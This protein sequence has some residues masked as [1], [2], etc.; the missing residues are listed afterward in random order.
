MKI[1]AGRII[2]I[3][4]K[5]EAL[6]GKKLPSG[7]SYALIKNKRALKEELECIFEQRN[8]IIKKYCKK[9]ENGEPVTDNEGRAE[10]EGEG[11]LRATEEYASFLDS[12]IEIDIKKVGF[13]EIEKCDSVEPLTVA[14][15]ELVEFMLD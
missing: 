3:A 12:E 15:M 13:E 8:S 9:D 1:K 14:E 7:L 2:E 11:E 10:F 6:D 5:I 4:G